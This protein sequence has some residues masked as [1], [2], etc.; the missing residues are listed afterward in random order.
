MRGISIHS[1]LAGLMV[2]AF[3]GN[4]LAH[5]LI[6]NASQGNLAASARFS[7]VGNALIIQLENTSTHDVLVPADILTAVFFDSGPALSLTRNS[8]TV[9][10]GSSVLFGTTDPGDVVGGEWAYKA[11][12]AGAPHG[13][14]YGVSSSGFDLFGPGDRFPGTN[15]QGPDSPD[16]LQYGLTSAGDDP[17]TGNT[18]VTGTNALIKNK[19]VIVLTGLPA[20]F[21]AH[22]DISNVSFQ[23]G[24]ALTE[25]NIPEPATLG[26][27]A[28]G[29][30]MAL[31]RAR[32]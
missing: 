2:A 3:C 27:L 23:Y 32:R 9:A 18:P 1:G 25:P 21:D 28:L 24:T 19:I 22:D 13:A 6:V 20:N 17:N 29:G 26:L 7:A 14:A 5:D 4:A 16:G 15:L 8:V 30:L 10:A 31:R 11:S 12:L